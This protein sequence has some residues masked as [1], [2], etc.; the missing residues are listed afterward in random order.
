MQKITQCPE[1]L[2][3]NFNLDSF[4]GNNQVLLRCVQVLRRLLVRNKDIGLFCNI[5][6]VTL[7]DVDTFKQC[8]DAL[9][10]IVKSRS[11]QEQ[12]KLFHDNAVKFYALV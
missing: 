10:T 12:R 6:A 7:R 4:G 8:L 2:L 11:E 3:G 5:A 9:K 1:Q